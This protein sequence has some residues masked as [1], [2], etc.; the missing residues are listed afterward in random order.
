MFLFEKRNR[1]T[2]QSAH[3]CVWAR[4][5]YAQVSGTGLRAPARGGCALSPR[6]PATH[7]KAPSMRGRPL[8]HRF[9]MPPPP[10]GEPRSA[11][12]RRYCFPARPWLSLWE[13]CRRRRLRG[14]FQEASTG[15][16]QKSP[17]LLDTKKSAPESGVCS[18]RRWG[19][20]FLD[21][22]T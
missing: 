21:I 6:L 2:F 7:Q 8:R 22:R 14:R 1:K 15:M 12:L 9:A 19:L 17:I 11:L 20:G 10:E 5:L 18:P 3:T 16:H 13:S 4:F